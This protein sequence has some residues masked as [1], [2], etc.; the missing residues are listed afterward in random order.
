MA[1]RLQDAQRTTDEVVAVVRGPDGAVKE[2]SRSG[3]RQ[4]ATRLAVEDELE[5]RSVDQL[6][7]MADDAGIDLPSKATKAR[8]LE[9][10]VVDRVGLG[11]EEVAFQGEPDEVKGPGPE[12]EKGA[13]G[14]YVNR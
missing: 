1:K 3:L 11:I 13:G 10:L 8:I 5:D 7:S 9:R 2:V 4:M 14:E 6:R 12:W